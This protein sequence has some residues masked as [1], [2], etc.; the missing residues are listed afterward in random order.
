MACVIVLP[1]SAASGPRGNV[2]MFNDLDIHA[3]KQDGTRMRTGIEG[4]IAGAPIQSWVF[5]PAPAV[6]AFALGPIT[7]QN[8]WTAFFG[9]ATP[10]GNE[11]TPR[12]GNT[13]PALTGAQWVEI[14][15]G[16]VPP[17]TT[18]T[19]NGPFGPAAPAQPAG[20]YT[21]TCK[22]RIPATGGASY[23]IIP[24]APSQMF[25]T[26]RVVFFADDFDPDGTGPLTGDGI[27]G[28]IVIQD[29]PDGP[30]PMILN[31]YDSNRDWTPNTTHTLRIEVNNTTDVIRYFLDNSLF[32]TGTVFA[33]SS[34]EQ[35]V[36]PSDNFHNPGEIGRLDDIA[37]EP[38]ISGAVCPANIVTTGTS[39]T[40][41]DVDDL[42]GVI[43]GWGPCPAPP[44]P[45]PANIVT[46]GTSATRVDVDDLLAVIG[47]WGP[48]P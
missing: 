17:G 5:E 34:I 20:Q 18:G 10:G 48:C 15:V 21:M 42:L 12:I 23:N 46:T 38:G 27:S 31:F 33:G 1:S 19:F 30:G 16:P 6:P 47:Q 3:F 35:V 26:C 39:A 9:Q 4:G 11:N 44:A 40:R 45:C 24:Q 43:G 14:P 36:I 2:A 8:G 13:A 25:L 22:I 7:G 29:D 28:D 41:V 32:Y 37:F